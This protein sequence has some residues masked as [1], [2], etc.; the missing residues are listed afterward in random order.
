MVHSARPLTISANSL[1]TRGYKG[2]PCSKAALGERK[3]DLLKGSLRDTGLGAKLMERADSADLSAGQK[4]KAIANPLGV[5][6][7]VNGEDEGAPRAGRLAHD[8]DDVAGLAKIE[9][10]ERLVHQ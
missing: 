5:R 7:L 9:A 10:V 8:L 1:A 6:K 2:A 4:N 3:K